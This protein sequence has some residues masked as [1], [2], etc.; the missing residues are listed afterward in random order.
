MENSK[1][2]ML[3]LKKT[4]RVSIKTD[5]RNKR[6]NSTKE[7]SRAEEGAQQQIICLTN[8]SEPL[9]SSSALL[10]IGNIMAT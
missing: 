5:P 7:D 3:P 4:I 2:T 6:E 9:G 10:W 1:E 8:I